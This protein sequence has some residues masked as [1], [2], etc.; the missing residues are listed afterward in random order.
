MEFTDRA[1]EQLLLPLDAVHQ[2]SC[3]YYYPKST[4]SQ[5]IHHYNVLFL[6]SRFHVMENSRSGYNVL[7]LQR[8]FFRPPLGY[9]V[10]R[11]DC[12]ELLV[13]NEYEYTAL[14]QPVIYSGYVSSS[15]ITL[16]FFG[17]QRPVQAP[18]CPR[19]ESQIRYDVIHTTQ[20]STTAVFWRYCR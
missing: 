8:T 5:R 9:V 16:Y 11:L 3:F 7:S 10:T 15:L 13:D 12:I 14:V 19:H 18:D 20:S 6:R 17:I 4:R 2:N 1:P